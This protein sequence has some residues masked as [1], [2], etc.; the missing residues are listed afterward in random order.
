[1]QRVVEAL[2]RPERGHGDDAVVGLA[3]PA[4][5][6]PPDMRGR[7]AVLT[8]PGI[9]DDQHTPTMRRGRRIREQQLK[10]PGVDLLVLPRRLRQEEL[11]TLH[12]RVLGT[13]HRLRPGQRGKRL[14]PL[15][16]QQQTAQVLAKPT[17]LGQRPEQ[18]VEPGRVPFQRP[19]SRR[20]RYTR[21]HVMAP[22]R[23]RCLPTDTADLTPCQQTT[24]KPRVVMIPATATRAPAKI[25][26]TSSRRRLPTL[27]WPGGGRQCLVDVFGLDGE[28]DHN[29]DHSSIVGTAP[30]IAP[31]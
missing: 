4:Q 23:Q 17:A 29:E 14:V 30:S 27:A 10:P 18:I 16:R 21:G 1:M 5:P 15:P 31:R 8:I 11:Q 22:P 6:L 13:G 2:V 25:L 3:Q 7:R 26:A 9:I 24:G 12:R 28:S 19:G 20:T